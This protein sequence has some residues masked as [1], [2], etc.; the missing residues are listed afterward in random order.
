MRVLCAGFPRAA[1]SGAGRGRGLVGL[2]RGRD[3]L[4]CRPLTSPAARD[5]QGRRLR[6]QQ[7]APAT[8]RRALVVVRRGRG[9]ARGARGGV[10]QSGFADAR[11]GGAEAT[12]VHRVLLDVRARRVPGAARG[13]RRR[14]GGR[15]GGRAAAGPRNAPAGGAGEDAGAAQGPCCPRHRLGRRAAGG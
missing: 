11:G 9:A 8:G 1:A 13:G 4:S 3:R 6:P 10:G 14:R 15:P 5:G 7:E 12:A 2:D